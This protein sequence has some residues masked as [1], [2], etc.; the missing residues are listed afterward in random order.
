[1]ITLKTE[2]MSVFRKDPRK[3][4]KLIKSTHINDETIAVLT[5]LFL[6][7]DAAAIEYPYYDNEYLS[8]FY[9]FYS[10]K[11]S[12]FPKE[13]YRIHL[14]RHGK[15][16]GF[17]TL[18]P[19]V[20]VTKIGKTY[21]NPSLFLEKDMF[22]IKNRYY[23]HILG[24]EFQIKAI[25]W[26]KQDTDL[27]VCGHV[28]VWIAAHV[29][30]LGNEAKNNVLMGDLIKA[31]PQLNT[32]VIPTSTINTRQMVKTLSEFGFSPM[33]IQKNLYEYR[34]EEKHEMQTFT[35]EMFAYI[36][37]HIAPIIC[38]G[39]SV[40]AV[41]AIGHGKVDYS[42]LDGEFK[43]KQIVYFADLIDSVIVHDDAQQPYL[44]VNY[45]RNI[46]AFQADSEITR[47]RLPAYYIEDFDGMIVPLRERIQYNFA[48]LVLRVRDYIVS[49]KLIHKREH[50]VERIFIVSAN[51][52]KESMYKED[53]NPIYKQILLSMNMPLH[54]WC[55]DFATF[56]EYKEQKMSMRFIV[57][58]TACNKETIPFLLIQTKDGIRTFENKKC[59][60]YKAQ[61]E[62]YNIFRGNLERVEE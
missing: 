27:A 62:P 8:T 34:I 45:K 32:R 56:D 57:D 14:L 17:L 19:T 40:H 52:L 30:R 33:N 9:L 10:K 35:N 15:Y 22:I 60:Y 55:V 58:T 54:V 28:A 31:V 36:E 41:T 5:K 46:N 12:S 37:S 59:H 4:K 47:E 24:R 20:G 25:P 51:E 38:I 1:M 11:H 42:K 39:N 3:W 2:S 16:E 29:A 7:C 50:Y 48:S 43:D 53:V 21:L 23:A 49:K 61:I 18:R 26:M 13:C 6:K 44:K